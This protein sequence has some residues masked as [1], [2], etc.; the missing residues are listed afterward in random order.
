MID[1]PADRLAD[2][3]GVGLK[4]SKQPRQRKKER[5]GGGRRGRQ[6]QRDHR[7]PPSNTAYYSAAQPSPTQTSPALYLGVDGDDVARSS[8]GGD[9]VLERDQDGRYKHRQLLAVRGDHGRAQQLDRRPHHLRV[10]EIHLGEVGNA[11][12]GHLLSRRMGFKVNRGW[13]RG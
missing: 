9:G 13:G 8:G 4:K 6:K 2:G 7:A 12:A 5:E 3:K 10:L 11:L 1:R